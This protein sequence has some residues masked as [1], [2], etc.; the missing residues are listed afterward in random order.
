MASMYGEKI[1]VSL[2]GQSHGEMIGCVVD[3]LPAGETIDEAKLS[4]F[5]QRRAPGGAYATQRK[6]AD[7]P[8]IVSGLFEGKT[9]GAPLCVL[10]ENHDVRSKDYDSLRDLP[11]PGHADYPAQVRYHGFQDVRGGGHF[12]ARVTAAL[13]AAGGIL[14]QILGRKGIRIGAHLQ[15]VG[16]VEDDR[17]D[18]LLVSEEDFLKAQT[19]F[20]TLS[21][22][23]EMH[24]K[25]LVDKVREEKDSVGGIVECAVFGLP[26]GLGEPMFNGIENAI[27]QTVFAIPA[28]KGI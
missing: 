10:I 12:S 22:E 18:P 21:A 16:D 7:F 28:V 8:R 13:C 14:I 27:A 24:I 23:A 4:A 6:E 9:C 26:V 5:M 17:F 20:P 19:G 2:F 15:R 25:A 11:R 1:K 3:G